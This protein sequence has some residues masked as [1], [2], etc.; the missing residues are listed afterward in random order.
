[1]RAQLLRPRN[2]LRNRYNDFV[3]RN[4]RVDRFLDD[5]RFHE[6]R[7]A[8]IADRAVADMVDRQDEMQ[9][10]P[11]VFKNYI[12]TLT[13]DLDSCIERLGEMDLKD[14]AFQNRPAYKYG[15]AALPTFSGSEAAFIDFVR[16]CIAYCRVKKIPNQLQDYLFKRAY[17]ADWTEEQVIA[18]REMYG[19]FESWLNGSA[20]SFTM[21]RMLQQSGHLVFADLNKKFLARTPQKK[22]QLSMELNNFQYQDETIRGIK[23]ESIPQFFTRARTLQFRYKCIGGECSE[24]TLVQHCASGLMAHNKLYHHVSQIL[25]AAPDCDTFALE[26]TLLNKMTLNNTVLK[27]KAVSAHFAQVQEANMAASTEQPR[28]WDQQKRAQS[29]HRKSIA[30][31]SSF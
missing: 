19:L 18:D 25:D 23:T 10:E 3:A 2:N 21:N 24:S 7:L 22:Q 6:E 1:M 11:E 12:S 20:K 15:K 28:P 29:L 4:N 26:T 9:P 13:S 17:R 8:A 14:G 16:E 27:K 30:S 5:R 31:L